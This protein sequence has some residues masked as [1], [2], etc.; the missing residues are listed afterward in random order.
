MSSFKKLLIPPG[1]IA[2]GRG[3]IAGS[4]VAGRPMWRRV[5][6]SFIDTQAGWTESGW[7]GWIYG[8]KLHLIT[9]VAEVWIPLAARLTAA[10]TTGD[11]TQ[12][13]A[14]LE[15]QPSDVRVILN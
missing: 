8:W 6:H 15:G 12:A 14:L 13:P 3:G 7:R 5:H 1:W 4:S 10:N 9:A 2:P 11:N